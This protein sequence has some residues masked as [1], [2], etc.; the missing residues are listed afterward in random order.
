MGAGKKTHNGPVQVELKTVEQ[1]LRI[2]IFLRWLSQVT[3]SERVFVS[4]LARLLGIGQNALSK[5][6]DI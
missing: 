5:A 1:K 4:G 6:C 3:L 2:D